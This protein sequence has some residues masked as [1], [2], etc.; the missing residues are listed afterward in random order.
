[1]T[2]KGAS[3]R[4]FLSISQY[5]QFTKTPFLIPPRHAVQSVLM[6]NKSSSKELPTYINSL[7]M[8]LKCIKKRALKSAL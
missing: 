8:N 2:E 6:Y 3:M 1:M 5:G 4:L 7:I